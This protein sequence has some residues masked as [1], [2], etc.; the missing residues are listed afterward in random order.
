[1]V[2]SFESTSPCK[3]EL[4]GARP[5]PG[6]ERAVDPDRA[7]VE[8]AALDGDRGL[9]FDDPAVAAVDRLLAAQRVAIVLG[10]ED[11]E[12][13]RGGLLGLDQ[14]ELRYL[15]AAPADAV[16]VEVLPGPVERLTLA[17]EELA[18]EGRL[19]GLDTRCRLEAQRRRIHRL[20]A[21]ESAVLGV[22]ERLQAAQD[23]LDR[24]LALGGDRDL[25]GDA[26]ELGCRR[27]L[28]A[29]D[30]D[31][32]R[33]G[34]AHFDGGGGAPGRGE[35][36]R[37][38][39]GEVDPHRCAQLRIRQRQD[40]WRR[41]PRVRR[42]G[43]LGRG[44]IA[45][46][47]RPRSSPRTKLQAP[48]PAG[49]VPGSGSSSPRNSLAST[50]SGARSAAPGA[51]EREE[52]EAE[53]VGRPPRRLGD[54]QPGVGRQCEVGE[55]D[56]PTGVELGELG[57]G[58]GQRI[59]GY[60]RERDA[61]E[62]GRDALAVPARR[63]RRL[64]AGSGRANTRA[65]GWTPMRATAARLTRKACSRGLDRCRAGALPD[66][67][68]D[69]RAGAR[70]GRAR[71]RRRAPAAAP[72]GPAGGGP[73]SRRGGGSTAALRSPRRR[74][75]PAGEAVPSSAASQATKSRAPFS[76]RGLASR[77]AVMANGS[78]TCTPA[79]S[80]QGG[81]AASARGRRRGPSGSKRTGQEPVSR[82][83]CVACRI[84]PL[85]SGCT[86]GECR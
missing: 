58:R 23:L 67:L 3:A 66:D 9:E 4:H 51:A 57:E 49:V 14:G 85:R 68:V 2:S 8:V 80:L 10:E 78:S 38:A 28:E 34:E 6:P 72:R 27:A 50:F 62:V 46:T 45:T 25:L 48:P 69:G 77:A 17:D 76:S 29:Q 83:I 36:R 20:I 44:A 16:D 33:P 31:R 75:A 32:L 53:A 24:D 86:A 22:L 70:G 1:M 47:R 82:S 63:A 37:D 61:V 52:G 60:R 13:H 64:S 55:G 56:R 59:V 74:C 19:D 41:L 35:R 7:A 73:G 65:S 42:G 84:F 11:L 81:S 18:F 39:G 79:H 21:Q 71:R 43:A 40:E 15:L 26:L 5:H 12:R 30:L 54:R